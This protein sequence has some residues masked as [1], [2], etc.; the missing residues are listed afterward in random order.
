MVNHN[1]D[2]LT[3][4]DWLNADF[5]TK[6]LKTYKHDQTV[7]VKSFEISP[8]SA[9]GEHFASVMYKVVVTFSSQK[10]KIDNEEI[11]MVIKLLPTGDSFKAK[12]V[13]ESPMFK[14]EIAMYTT[15][16]PEMERILEQA[17]ESITLAPPLIYQNLHD[18]PS[19]VLILKDIRPDGFIVPPWGVDSYETVKVIARTLARFHATSML[20]IEQGTKLDF[21]DHF[22]LSTMDGQP[23]VDVF[24]KPGFIRLVN[25]LRKYEGFEDLCDQLLTNADKYF[26]GLKESYRGTSAC[27][28]KV[29]NH[30]DFHSKNILIRN[31]GRTQNDFRLVE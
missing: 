5:F 2:E 26:E 25:N 14:N 9:M 8:G 30:G 29:L 4:P 17:G 7:E 3:S 28:Y 19:P 16:I 12:A 18:H 11:V 13:K 27:G 1:K 21:G 6:V 10:Y 24:I 15:V 22:F 20:M 31:G 23:K